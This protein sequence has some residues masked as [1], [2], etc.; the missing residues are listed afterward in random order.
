MQII[1]T[2]LMIKLLRISVLYIS[3][4]VKLSFTTSGK[5]FYDLGK[6]KRVDEIQTPFQLSI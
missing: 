1:C 6:Q 2:R 3:P 4:Q 5:K